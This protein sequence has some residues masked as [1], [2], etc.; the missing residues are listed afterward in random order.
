MTRNRILPH[1]LD[2]ERSVLGGVLLSPKGFPEVSDQV[3]PPDFY[4]PAHAA[5]YEAMVFLSTASKPIDA[6]SVAEQM[7][8]S[9]SLHS[10][11][12]VRGEAYFGELMNAVVTVENLAY[13][14]RIVRSKA[15]ARRLVETAT[16]IAA[17]GCSDYGEF[18]D[19]LAESQQAVCA[20]VQ[21]DQRGG[22]VPVKKMLPA[23]FD[24][25]EKRYERKQVVTGVPTGY[26]M[27]DD[28][29][30]G[31]QPGDLIIGAARPSMGKTALALNIGHHAGLQ[32]FP[33]LV[34]SL[35]M[36]G[37]SL[38]ERLVASDA[39]INSHHLRLG[40]LEDRDWVRFTDASSRLAEMPLSIDDSSSLRLVDIQ[41]RARRWRA[42][43]AHE[44]LGL[45]IVDY[46]Q[47]IHGMAGRT[48]EQNREREIADIS[49][50]LKAL[51]KE[52]HVPVLALSQLNRS[53]ES[54]ADKR[55]QLSDLR[56]SGAIEQDADV[57]AF[58]Y[59]DEVYNKDSPDKNV[60]EIIVAKQRNGSTSTVRLAFLGKYTR[61]ENLR[62][63][64]LM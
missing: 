22:P 16:E 15:T 8:A 1:D 19:Y 59:R 40:R 5:I 21:R 44:D 49:R 31:L 42:A 36:D 60:A 56:E 63:Q 29:T 33:V 27:L 32:G 52:L 46:L 26:H 14:A 64:S 50:G 51:A 23:L 20:I 13:H 34:F 54:R 58:I 9:Q 7:R 25:I 41:N 47:L 62:Q 12:G 43:H 24:A 2:A 37:Q 11:N 6:I 61:F 55:P 18:D 39:R 3:S 17:K 30:L 38:L 48:R 45:I 28:L 35:E 53:V 4:H 57:I 10:L